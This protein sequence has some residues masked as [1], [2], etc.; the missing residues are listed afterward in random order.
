MLVFCI[1]RPNI[2]MGGSFGVWIIVLSLSFGAL[3][4]VLL[5]IADLHIL[6]TL[7]LRFFYTFS[8]HFQHV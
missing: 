8:T 5:Y 3:A 6:Y 1:I 7:I 4:Q 2:I